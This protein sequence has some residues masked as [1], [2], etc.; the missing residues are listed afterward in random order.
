M[1]PTRHSS[2]AAHRGRR[3]F[4]TTDARARLSDLLAVLRARA[5][6]WFACAV[7]DAALALTGSPPPL[8]MRMASDAY[9]DSSGGA[10]F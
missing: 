4:Y 9:I 7:D 10:I 1:E 8:Y 5:C 6:A 3:C 2:A